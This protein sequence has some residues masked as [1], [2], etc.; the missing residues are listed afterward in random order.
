MF[1]HCGNLR[2]IPLLDTSNVI[3]MQMMF[4]NCSNLTSIP[5]LDMSKVT[6]MGSMFDGCVA[7]KSIPLLD[8]GKIQYAWSVFGMSDLSHLVYLGGFKD[9]GKQ[10]YVD[11]LSSEFLSRLPNV[12]HE[13]LMNV[14]NNLY[15]RKSNGL[16]NL[17]ID[18]G[19]INLDKLTI[20]EISIAVNKGWTLVG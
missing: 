6:N 14:I 20:D 4:Y 12:S 8:W 9:L 1:L 18:F 7:L 16:N 19:T 3:D 17:D 11:G 13:S 10:S 15:D 2:T 5:L